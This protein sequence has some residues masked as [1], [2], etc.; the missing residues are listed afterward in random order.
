VQVADIMAEKAYTERDP[1]RIALVELGGYRAILAVPML[2]DNEVVGVINI[3]RQQTGAFR[4]KQIELVKNF[5]TQ[6]VVAIENTRL[7]SELRES[8]SQQT[9]TSE[10]LRI[11]SRAPGELEPVFNAI[12]ENA[13]RICEAKLGNMF[14]REGD[15]FCAVAVH[16]DSDYANWTRREPVVH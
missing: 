14:V 9:A 15:S 4:E 5:A 7:L 1:N 11:I 6:A 2:K 12:L 16:G 3:Y 8:L 10:V 13:T